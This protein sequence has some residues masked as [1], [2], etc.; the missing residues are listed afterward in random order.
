[1]LPIVAGFVGA[2]TV[3]VMTAADITSRGLRLQW[4]S[5]PTARLR[6]G[7]ASGCCAVGGGRPGLEGAKISQ[8]CTRR[9]APSR[10]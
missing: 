8:G 9:P 5:A 7:R 6:S 1:M 2:D 3:G 4:I 10:P